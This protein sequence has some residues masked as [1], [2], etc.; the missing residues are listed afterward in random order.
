MK[1]ILLFALLLGSALSTPGAAQAVRRNACFPA[2]SAASCR[3][4][5]VLEAGV[6]TIL[7]QVPAPYGSGP[8]LSWQAGWMWNRG[9]RA[10]IGGTIYIARDFSSDRTRL[11]L[12]PRYRLQLGGRSALTVAAGPALEL[13]NFD[14]SMV[15]KSAGALGEVSLGW[16]DQIALTTQVEY[17]PTLD[18]RPG[19]YWHAGIKLGSYPGLVGAVGTGLGFALAELIKALNWS[20]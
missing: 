5:L 19:L 6:G 10:A 4:F 20:E 2:G 16:G 8:D 14:G 3:S 17:L 11:A 15:I 9:A 1:H 18:A 12:L 7:A 13:G